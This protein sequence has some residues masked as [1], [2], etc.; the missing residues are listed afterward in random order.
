MRP[1][2]VISMSIMAA[3]PD[4]LSLADSLGWS[5]WPL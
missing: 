4:P 5:R 2:R 3:E 1:L